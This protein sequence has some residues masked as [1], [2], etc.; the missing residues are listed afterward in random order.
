MC[1]SAPTPQVQPVRRD[2]STIFILAKKARGIS[3]GLSSI[4]SAAYFR[5]FKLHVSPRFIGSLR[6]RGGICRIDFCA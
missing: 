6:R 2:F 3:A 4:F 5:R 1:C